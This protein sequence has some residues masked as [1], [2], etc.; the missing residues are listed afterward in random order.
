MY[1]WDPLLSTR[2]YHNIV[3][4]GYTP[5]QNIKVFKTFFL[6]KRMAGLSSLSVPGL[7]T[8]APLPAAPWQTWFPENLISWYL[9]LDSPVLLKLWIQ[10]SFMSSSCLWESLRHCPYL[11]LFPIYIH[12][13]IYKCH[14]D[15]S[16]WMSSLKRREKELSQLN[17]CALTHLSFWI[18]PLMQTCLDQPLPTA[19][20]LAWNASPHPP[21][22]NGALRCQCLQKPG[23][24]IWVCDAGGVGWQWQL[25]FTSVLGL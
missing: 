21:L 4:W 6:K 19:F 25:T 23:G 1:G 13:Y 2:N 16:T 20:A 3:N 7:G 12:L 24:R 9:L 10:F 22:W 17:T 14:W 15:L 5:I 11:W 8:L 18:F